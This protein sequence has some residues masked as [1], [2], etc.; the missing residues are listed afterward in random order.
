VADRERRRLIE[1]VVDAHQ[2]L[3]LVREVVAALEVHR[4]HGADLASV[5][6]VVVG[7]RVEI[8]VGRI[9]EW[10]DVAHGRVRAP[11][12]VF[13]VGGQRRAI[14][15]VFVLAR[16]F[17]RDEVAQ[18]PELN[19]LGPL[20]DFITRE[21]TGEYEYPEDR[22]TLT[23]DW[24]H[25]KWGAYAAVSY[26]GPFQDAP[27]SNLDTVPDYNEVDTREVGSMTTVN[28]QGRYNFTDKIKLLVSVDNAFDQA[29]PFA[30]GD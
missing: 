26:I 3:D 23:A 29:P 17:A 7:N 11:L 28:L 18:R 12:V 10:P 15:G 30:I 4:R 13:P 9:L 24:E 25:D 1:G 20:G 5:D 6:L 2:Q 21:V 14:L 8:G 27:D 22:A 16:H 19:A